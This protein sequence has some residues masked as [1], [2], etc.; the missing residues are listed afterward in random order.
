ML[1]LKSLKS[2]MER[3]AFIKMLGI[4]GL[5]AGVSKLSSLEKWTEDFTPTAQM[6]VLFL[7]HGSPMNAIEENEFVAGFRKISSEIPQPK[8]ILCI[9]AHWYTRGTMVTAMDI[10]KTIH[11]FGGFPDALYEVQ[12]PAPG[13]PVLAKET[14]EILAPVVVAQDENWGLDHGAW[15][16][17]K[18]L[19][20]K[21]N[22]PVIQMSIDYTQPAS[23]HFDLAKRLNSLRQKGILIVGSGNIVHNL[24]LVDW[25]NLNKTDYGFDWAV[26]ARSKI[27]NWMLD[28]D[29]QPIIDYTKQ[30][31][32]IQ[33]AAPSPDHYLPLVYTLGLKTNNDKIALFNDKLLAGSL[34]MTSVYIG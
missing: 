9:S 6:P 33:L 12:Y 20:P 15:S 3:K 7:G 2:C 24:G 27:N 4:S 5:A 21:A 26:E 11:D 18:H 28:G 13:S 31:K 14:A 29:F 25:K 1:F 10:P 22:V 30:G 16:V 34:S 17:I 8:A 23:Y 19:Y 32:S